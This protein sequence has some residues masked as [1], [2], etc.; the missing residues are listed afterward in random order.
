MRGLHITCELRV[1]D[2]D[3]GNDVSMMIQ[4][5]TRTISTIVLEENRPIIW[6]FIYSIHDQWL[7]NE[8]HRSL[9]GEFNGRRIGENGHF[10]CDK[11]K[12]LSS[13][14]TIEKLSYYNDRIEPN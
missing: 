11:S 12:T 8:F 6:W 3:D 9:N 2:S 1:V 5:H 13:S 14:S 10:D 4:T 7:E